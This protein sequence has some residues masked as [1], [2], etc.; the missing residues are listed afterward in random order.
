MNVLR[1]L[2]G[3]EIVIGV[4]GSIAAGA[5]VC[6]TDPAATMDEHLVKPALVRLIGILVTK[7]PLAEDARGVACRLQNLGNRHGFQAHALTLKNRVRH[8][9]LELVL[10]THDRG[11]R[12]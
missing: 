2:E 6:L 5:G 11:S 12:R 4:T 1:T 9:V 7:V 8:P 10:A 3:K